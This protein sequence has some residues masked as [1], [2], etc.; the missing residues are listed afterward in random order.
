[1]SSPIFYEFVLKQRLTGCEW[2]GYLGLRGDTFEDG[3]LDVS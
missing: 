2:F 1:M 3:R